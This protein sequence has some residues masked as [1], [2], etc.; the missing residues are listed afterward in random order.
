M[1]IFFYGED[2]FRLKQKL[3]EL[4]EKFIASSLGEANLVVLTGKTLTFEE[5]VR[6]VL[7]IPFLSRK[8]LLVVENFLKNGSP[9]IQK[10]VADFLKPHKKSSESKVPD[11]TILVFI[12]EGC[13]DRR[14]ILFK[15]LKTIGRL[16]EFTPLSEEAMRA[17]IRKE[18]LGRGGEV[19]AEVIR[20][21][22]AF[23]GNDL[24]RMSN[25]ISKL[26]AYNRLINA[27][28]VEML[29]NSQIQANIF[30]LCEAI[31]AK[32]LS[33]AMQELVKLLQSGYAELYILTMII[34]EYRNLLI[35]KD[36]LLRSPK[37][38]KWSLSAKV[39][40]HP[41]VV[42]KTLP[43]AKK[44]SLDELKKKYE[45]ILYFE[46]AIKTGKIEPKIALELLVF[47]LMKEGHGKV[48][49]H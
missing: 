48:V 29:V 35:I 28:S 5:F 36:A 3:R 11:S 47:D 30:E 26:L 42:G 37:L 22:A 8:R 2:T 46:T 40:L 15:T 25:E 49:A 17:W 33:R 6:Q 19:E 27:A 12:E 38:N 9:T 21:L 20:K 1:I 16:Q 13:P 10:K 23:V 4:K 24:W 39:K 14:E 18:V 7:A 44:Y 34:Y 32:S 45:K 43:M 41:Y 31:A